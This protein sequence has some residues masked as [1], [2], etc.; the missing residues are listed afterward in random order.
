MCVRANLLHPS[1]TCSTSKVINSIYLSTVGFDDADV[2]AVFAFTLSIMSLVVNCMLFFDE[3]RGTHSIVAAKV[4]GRAGT[5]PDLPPCSR[6]VEQLI[7][8][9][10]EVVD[11]EGTDLLGT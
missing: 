11:I 6:R 9:G 5:N 2:I 3:M 10:E 1:T 4:S 8:C 7:R